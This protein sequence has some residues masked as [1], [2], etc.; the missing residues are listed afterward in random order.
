M[1]TLMYTVQYKHKHILTRAIQNLMEILIKFAMP[2][3]I[4]PKQGEMKAAI[5]AYTQHPMVVD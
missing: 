4:I 3:F 1:A 5:V 2:E